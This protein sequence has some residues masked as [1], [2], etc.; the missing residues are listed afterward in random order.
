MSTSINLLQSLLNISYISSRAESPSIHPRLVFVFHIQHRFPGSARYT[1]RVSNLTAN[2]TMRSKDL[3]IYV[4][5]LVPSEPLIELGKDA[6]RDFSFGIDLSHQELREIEKFREGKDLELI[7]EVKF[8]GERNDEPQ[9]KELRRFQLGFRIAKSDWV[10]SMLPQM[11]F[12]YVSLIEIP[13]L[14]GSEFQ[15]IVNHVNDAW[16]Q[17]SMGEY[18]RVLTDCR[19]ALEELSKT[20]RSKGF[21]KEATIKE[22]KHKVPDWN[23]LFGNKKLGTIIRNINRKTLGFVAKGSHAGTSINRENADFA[24]MTTHGL[25]NLATKKLVD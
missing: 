19:K 23:K 18:D 2:L 16:K 7:I 11:K 25:V 1:L 12:K 6:S 5:Q 15:K 4:G 14:M 17:Y 22:K 20:I 8:V 13:A 3:L 9:N 10:E 24:L 21:E